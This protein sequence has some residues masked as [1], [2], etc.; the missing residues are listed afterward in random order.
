M[1]YAAALLGFGTYRQPL[2]GGRLGQ[3]PAVTR[4]RLHLLLSPWLL[5]P[6]SPLAP[7][8]TEVVALGAPLK[9][10]RPL[11]SRLVAVFARE[12]APELE[13]AAGCLHASRWAEA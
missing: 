13:V 6:F 3:G 7:L 9:A 5:L 4:L 1:L 12:A 11:L 10:A 8:P 2:L